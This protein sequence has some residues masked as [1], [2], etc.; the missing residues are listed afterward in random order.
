MIYQDQTLDLSNSVF[1]R[2]ITG[3]KIYFVRCNWFWPNMIIIINNFDYT[4]YFVTSH[5][6]ICTT[7]RTSIFSNQNFSGCQMAITAFENYR[8][9][10]FDILSYLMPIKIME[11]GLILWVILFIYNFKYFIEYSDNMLL[12]N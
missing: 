4:N 6:K 12:Y 1:I 5:S 8:F 2:S 3:F 9:L 10:N 7:E 11:Y